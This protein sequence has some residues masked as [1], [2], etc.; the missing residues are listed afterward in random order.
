MNNSLNGY[1]K[2]NPTIPSWVWFE[3]T[4][5][6]AEGQGVC[7]N[8]DCGTATV[9]DGRRF[10]RVELPSVTNARYFAGV[11]A[12][13]YSAKATGQFIEI[14]CPGSVCNV[15]SKANCVLGGGILTCQAGGTEAGY[16]SRA[17]FQGE[18]SAVPI[19]TMDRSTTAGKVQAK[20]QVG[21]PSGLI[22]VVTPLAAGGATALMVGGVTYLA[23]T[24]TLAADA[25]NTLADGTISGL[26]KKIFCEG[27]YTTNGV[28]VTVT[29]GEQR[30]RSVD[31]AIVAL[32]SVEFDAADEV[33]LLEWR[34]GVW[35][36]LYSAGA[37]LA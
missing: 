28:N 19:Q 4:T 20:L 14:Y 33:A 13:D 11:A 16:F 29:H 7:F 23:G 36:E 1:E 32:A 24:V 10:N 26:R 15:L 3:G 30:V 5:A 21:E 31:G 2:Q 35:Y 17:G 6:L 18:G 34:D 9:S 37:T 8:N 27:T 25:T 22:E 12:R